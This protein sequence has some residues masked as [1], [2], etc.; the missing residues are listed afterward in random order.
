MKHKLLFLLVALL[1]T[2]TAWADDEMTLNYS[3]D[4]ETHTATVIGGD[5]VDFYVGDIVI[6]ATV[7]HNGQD[8]SVT[9]IGDE[10]F[11]SCPSLTSVVIPD[12]VTSIGN[13]TFSGCSSLTSLNIPN[14]VK[15][16]D[17][18]AFYGCSSL[19]SVNIPDGVTSIGNSTFGECS[20]LTS[21]S[22]PSSVTLIDRYAFYGCTSLTSVTIPGSV[23]TLD[24][25]AFFGCKKLISVTLNSNDVVSKSYNASHNLAKIFGGQVET[26]II[27]ESVT[28]IGEWAFDYCE[29][30]TSVTLPESVTSIGKCAFVSC[31]SLTSIT[32][33]SSVTSIGEATFMSC[34]GLTSITIPNKVTSIGDDAFGGC[35]GLTSVEIPNSVTSIGDYAFGGCT[36]LTDVYCN[37]DP[38]ALDWNDKGTHGFMAD[39]ATK[40]HVADASVWEEK[41]PDA[42]VTFVGDLAP[43]LHV[44]DEF[45]VDGLIYK[46]T[47]ESP[48]TLELRGFD[49]EKPTGSFVIPEKTIY[50][51]GEYSVTAIYTYAFNDCTEL[52]SV[53]LP[54]SVAS[55]NTG[56]FSSCPNLTSI[57]VEEGNENYTSIDGVLFDQGG[58]RLYF[59]P[60]G[61]T[62]ASY[63]IPDGVTRI[64]TTALHGNT[65]L[66]SV[67]LPSSMEVLEDWAFRDMK[68]LKEITIPSSVT[69]IGN[70]AFSASG[71]TSINIPAS[72]TSIGGGAFADC[73]NLTSFT[74]DAGNAN[75]SFKDGVLFDKEGTMLHTYIES[76][77]DASYTVPDGVTSI[78]GNAFAT[79]ANLTSITFS[80]SLTDIGKYAFSG[81]SGLTSVTIPASVTNIDSRAFS[82]C[83]S[84]TDV[85]CYA[86]PSNLTW[87]ATYGFKDGKATICHVFDKEAFEA[88]WATGNARTDANVTFVGDLA[89][90]FVE[91]NLRYRVLH[92]TETRASVRKAEGQNVVELV[93]SV[94]TP[95]GAVDIPAS[96]KHDGVDYAVTSIGENAFTNCSGMT[97]VIIPSSVTNIEDG[98]FDGCTGLTDVYCKADPT[99]L[100]WSADAQSFMA[101]K[102]TKFHVEDASAWS[103]FSDANVTFVGD[104]EPDAIE[105]IDAIDTTDGA[106]Y[107]LSGMKLEDKPTEKGVYIYNGKKI[108]VQ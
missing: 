75:Y 66:E 2:M 45:T 108:L 11:V 103:A 96:V 27:G 37:A 85:Y 28:S 3:F 86:D 54:K 35:S 64:F 105:S 52:T 97:S 70:L 21:V 47:G 32:I 4:E 79:C 93:G 51:Q 60:L 36:G 22:I 31:K 77:G 72:V 46:V 104:L 84:V 67:I 50:G 30:L 80:E 74:V 71:L 25:S 62:D 88:K 61:R 44:G 48:Y 63:T 13:R 15:S 59:Y 5:V 14:S 16:I 90:F 69:T 76:M 43:E 99:Q 55:I 34:S 17:E 9:S 89:D 42:N 26:Y 39:K 40:F 58:K 49:G 94:T 53:K 107:T 95:S 24:E 81:C 73:P 10:A 91:D 83:Y 12:G 56:V 65:T 38:S 18:L 78:G 20:S 106:W 68:N 23:T 100:T 101:D 1:S 8:Y 41:F 6:P 19:T 92:Q 29:N 57:T 87:S 102:A 33:P 98:A 82:S 7:N